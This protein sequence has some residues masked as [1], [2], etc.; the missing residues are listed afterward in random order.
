[1]RKAVLTSALVLG[2]LALA[3]APAAAV[4]A[5]AADG[6]PAAKVGAVV[7]A[8][9]AGRTYDE[10]RQAAGAA[11][12]PYGV[13]LAAVVAA[14]GAKSLSATTVTRALKNGEFQIDVSLKGP[15]N[16]GADAA[17]VPAIVPFAFMTGGKCSGGYVSGYPTPDQTFV[18]DMSGSA[19]NVASV[20]A[21]V[22]ASYSIALDDAAQDA[23][24]AGDA[25]YDPS[26]TS[27][28]DL[29]MITYAGYN[30]VRDYALAH[31]NLFIPA[32]GD[33]GPLREAITQSLQREGYEAADVDTASTPLA[34]LSACGDEA[35][36]EVRFYVGPKGDALQLVAVTGKRLAA[37]SYDPAVSGDIQITTPIDCGA[38]A[39]K[40]AK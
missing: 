11:D 16:L 36:T 39:P 8:A 19:C 35:A 38:P 34:S 3:S 28:Y 9:A 40:A 25:E 24:G 10:A 23:A 1:M 26:Q 15:A 22:K 14:A 13:D 27:D 21:A 30:G 37:Y 6:T 12:N 17:S 4:D 29:E 33:L 32:G 7:L 31:D 5:P 2:M 20:A 18:V